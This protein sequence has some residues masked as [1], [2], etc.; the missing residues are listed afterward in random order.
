VITRKDGTRQLTYDGAPLYTFSGD[1]KAGQMD[2]QGLNV[3]GGYW[4]M[5][6]A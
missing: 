5:V 4:W 1:T 6:V 3:S 2:G